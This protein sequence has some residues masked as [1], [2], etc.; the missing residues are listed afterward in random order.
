MHAARVE[1][2]HPVGVGHPAVAD[3]GLGRIEFVETN[4]R[5]PTTDATNSCGSATRI[6]NLPKARSDTGSPPID[7]SRSMTGSFVPH[8]RSWK[9]WRATNITLAVK[10]ASPPN[11]SP[12]VFEITGTFIVVSV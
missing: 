3:T 7:G 6:E 4:P 5:V 10:G 8:L 11:G 1:L 2:H 9:V 12:N